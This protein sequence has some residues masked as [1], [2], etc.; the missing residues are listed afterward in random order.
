MAMYA[1]QFAVLVLRGPHCPKNRW[2]GYEGGLEFWRASPS[3]PPQPKANSDLENAEGGA[4][5][6]KNGA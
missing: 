5:D 3:N 6:E 1:L 4:V 2:F